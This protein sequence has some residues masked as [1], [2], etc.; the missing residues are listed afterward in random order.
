MKNKVQFCI[1][2]LFFLQSPV[3]LL[4][5]NGSDSITSL[6]NVQESYK[7]PGKKLVELSE[8]ILYKKT[9]QIDLYMY[10]LRPNAPAKKSLPAIIYFYGGGWVRGDAENQIQTA[11]WFRDH[12]IIAITAEYRVKSRSGTSPLACI[13]DAKSAVRYVRENAK[14]LGI[15]PNEII[16]AGGSAGGHL[17]LSTL[18]E[19]GDAAG[20]NLQISTR[21]NALVLHNPVTGVGFGASFFAE[22]PEFSPILHIKKGWPPI[23][24]SNGT[25]DKTTPY[26][27][28]VEFGKKMEEI[29]NRCELITVKEAD[30]SCDWPITNPNFLPTLTRMTEFLIEQGFI[31][32]QKKSK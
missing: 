10:L 2:M 31:K 5:Q 23:I 17:A 27:G 1:L 30:H 3:L 25:D 6:V 29:G 12:G 15:N 14:K 18:L 8:A 22:H 13:E 26:A 7:I 4:A 28:A 9:P 16:A 21:P 32:K 19:G 20:E 24:L 11:A